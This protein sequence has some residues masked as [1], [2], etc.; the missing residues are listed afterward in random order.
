[1]TNQYFSLT[2]IIHI[3]LI[4]YSIESIS[5]TTQTRLLIVSLDGFRQQYLSTYFLPTLNR[6]QNQGIRTINGMQP[7]YVTMTYPNHISIATGM[8]QED[9]GI[10]HNRFFDTK[11]GKIVTFDTRDEGQWSDPKVEPIWITATKQ[12]KRSAVLYWPASHNEFHGVRPLI[13]NSLYSD[14]IPMREKID[15]AISY[16]RENIIQLAMLYHYEPDKQGHVYGP[17]S[18]ETREALFRLDTDIEYLLNKVKTEL[19]D[20]LN[21]II[22]SDHGMTNIVRLVQ[23]FRDGYINKSAVE[24]HILDGPIFSLSPRSGE[25]E[26]VFNGLR[27]IPGVTVYKR[28]EFPEKYHYSKAIYRIGE[29][30]VTPNNEGVYFSQATTEISSPKG[31]HGYDN[32]LPSMQAIFMAQGPDFN[33]NKEIHSLKNV[34]VY[35]IACKILDLKP[36]PYATAGSLNNLTD[37]FHSRINKCS[38]SCIGMSILLLA[39]FIYIVS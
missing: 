10:I 14:S 9:H 26:Q 30:I 21:I 4:I 29:I 16:F 8:Y 36:N 6:I 25:F 13:Y 32:T 3:I 38:Q 22:L 2:I 17:D 24:D 20:D 23:P 1:M 28:D 33:Q 11:L 12:N 37:I 39:F 7:T 35:H 27:R 34:D 31:N 5:S 18:N 15:N 19:N